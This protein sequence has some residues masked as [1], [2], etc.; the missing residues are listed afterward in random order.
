MPVSTG[1]QTKKP[2]HPCYL[3]LDDIRRSQSRSAVGSRERNKRTSCSTRVPRPLID[4]TR[5]H[6]LKLSPSDPFCWICFLFFFLLP[7][8]SRG[9]GAHHSCHHL[10]LAQLVLVGNA[11]SSSGAKRRTP[12]A[13]SWPFVLQHVFWAPPVKLVQTSLHIG[14]LETYGELDL[15]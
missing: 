13:G 7:S 14:R 8:P 3:R 1:A 9:G 5:D 4:L 6:G 12:Y 11:Y 15:D 10:L 2:C